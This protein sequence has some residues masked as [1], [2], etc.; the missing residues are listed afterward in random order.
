MLTLVF[1]R[2]PRRTTPRKRAET[3]TDTAE[4]RRIADQIRSLQTRRPLAYAVLVEFVEQVC[5]RNH[6]DD[7]PGA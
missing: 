5:K 2:G 6:T 7:E 1:S 3:A 4:A